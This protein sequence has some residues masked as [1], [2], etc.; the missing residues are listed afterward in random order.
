M[1]PYIM[2]EAFLESVDS[3]A[4]QLTGQLQGLPESKGTGIS[5]LSYHAASIAAVCYACVETACSV[6]LGQ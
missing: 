3:C 1:Y 5:Q 2:Q 4:S 6:H